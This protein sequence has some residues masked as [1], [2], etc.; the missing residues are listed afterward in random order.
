MS[1]AAS[2][3][4]GGGGSFRDRMHAMLRESILEAAKARASQ[5]DWSQ[6]RIADIAEDVG[7]SRQTI[8]NEFGSKDQLGQAVFAHEMAAYTAGILETTKDAANLG[9]AIRSSV[10]WILAQTRANEMVQRTLRDA[11]TGHSSTETLLPL[12]TVNAHHILLP[13]RAAL[14]DY[15]ESRWPSGDLGRTTLLVELV[16]R[17]VI[18]FVIVP[19]DLPE[20]VMVD[21]I[22]DMVKRSL[23]LSPA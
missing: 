22:V 10:T 14:V 13:A 2:K 5:V 9:E 12:L 8:Y 6:V 17:F 3:Q 7:V 18:S 11:R 21:T 20:E 15:F 23:D 16:I 1:K 4:T 19:S